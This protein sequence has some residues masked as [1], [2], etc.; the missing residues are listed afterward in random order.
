MKKYILS[1]LVAF[2]FVLSS[3][4]DS[5][6]P[7]SSVPVRPSVSD[8]AATTGSYDWGSYFY[9]ECCDEWIEV[10]ATIRS[11]TKDGVAHFNPTGIVGESSNGTTYHGGGAQNEN[12]N[13]GDGAGH[14]ISSFSIVMTSANGCH[15]TVRI[16]VHYH[17][18]ANGN[19]VVDNVTE[20]FDCNPDG[21]EEG[22]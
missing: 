18:D 16:S 20:V 6:S 11:A 19:V 7:N 9:N 1:A 13:E 21:E 3:C 15:F 10:S 14:Y 8:K 22:D 12:Y 2:A 17:W 4:A 5:S